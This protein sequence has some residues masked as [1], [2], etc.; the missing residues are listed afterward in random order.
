MDNV[1]KL[2]NCIMKPKSAIDDSKSRTVTDVQV[3]HHFNDRH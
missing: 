1:Q 3:V 2:K